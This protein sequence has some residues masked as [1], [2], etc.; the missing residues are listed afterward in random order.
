MAKLILREAG[1]AAK[2]FDLDKSGSATIGRAPDCDIP[3]SDTQASRRHCTVVRLQSGYEVSDLGST[4]GTLVNSTLTKRQKLKHGDVIRIGAVE[5]VFDDPSSAAAPGEAAAGYLI[6]ARGDRK[7]QKFEL[8]GQ[9]T[10]IGRKPTN[11]L[12]I[13][14]PVSS[15]YHCE[16]VRDLN[17]Y[18][19]RDL[20][21]T[22]GTLVNGEMVTEAQLSHGA[23]IRIGNTRFV[24]QDPAMAE[25][26][27]ELAGGEEE[28]EWGMMRDIDLAAVRKR[29]P[30][31]IVYALLFV[32]IM[33]AGGY[34]MTVG[35]P[36]AEDAGPVPPPG[37]L[38]EP[39][40][41]ESAAARFSWRAEPASGVVI[42]V[43]TQVHGQG[44]QSLEL[45][46][47]VADALGFY[48][49]TLSAESARYRLKG[50]VAVRGG[51]KARLGLQWLGLALERWTTGP[52]IDSSGVTTVDLAATAPPWASRVR[53][54]VRIEGA[55]TVYLDDVSL[56]REAPADLKDAAGNEFRLVV[57]DGRWAD[58]YYAQ[59]PILANGRAFACDAGGRELDSGVTMRAEVQGEEHILVT[60]EAGGD[61]ARAGV[62]FEEVNGFL[63]RGGF[64][65]F[66]PDAPKTFHPAFPD[67]GALSLEGTRKLLLGPSTRAFA[68]LAETD[69]GRLDAE[70][71][72]EGRTRTFALTGPVADGRFAFRFKVDLRGETTLAN[73]KMSGALE[74]HS[75][76]RWGDFLRAA[77]LALAEFPF[78]SK[79]TR[80]QLRDLIGQANEAYTKERDRIDRLVR[81]YKDFRD[82]QDLADAGGRLE[83]LRERFQIAPGEGPPGEHYKATKEEIDRLDFEARERRET[84]IADPIFVQAQLV[85][86][87]SSPPDIHSAAL[88][89]YYI[90]RF[91]PAAKQAKQARAELQNIQK[92]HPKI[93]AVLDA[94]GFAGGGPEN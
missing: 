92:S 63:S 59:A 81:E 36:K 64:R 58:L 90:V 93:V 30:A 54:G 7:G 53:L 60:I 33:G 5:V 80:D 47:S 19:I 29:N 66:T 55:G 77:K 4:N 52:V 49:T 71:R 25:I 61:A 9:R 43:S 78:A 76:G 88:Q 42:G 91:L 15:S 75:S 1:G 32:G 69:E 28:D 13:E 87:Q 21:S 31:T 20:G 6:H 79:S 16:I 24:F 11:A 70:A 23:R 86:M 82:I 41:F 83:K 8:T 51:A 10:T 57:A 67:E 2:E 46:S 27:L 73:Q 22:N 12:V 65:A 18:T 50:G 62:V 17:G 89:F 44:K 39:F 40:S 68:A 48:T 26:D 94:L 35:K 45:R 84:E 14:D 3:I 37:N 38:H 34:F 85:H 72:V 74:L 56:V